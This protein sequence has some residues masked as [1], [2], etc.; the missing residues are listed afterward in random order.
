MVETDE[1]DKFVIIDA[2]EHDNKNTDKEKD[3]PTTL[4]DASSD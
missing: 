3:W 2:D 4:I 1:K